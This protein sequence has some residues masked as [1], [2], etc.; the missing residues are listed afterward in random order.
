M[1]EGTDTGIEM[2]VASINALSPGKQLEFWERF[3]KTH[4]ERIARTEA[5][6][7]PVLLREVDNRIDMLRPIVAA[8]G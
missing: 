4:R 2:L 1:T 3:R 6:L 7:D 8:G 5:Q